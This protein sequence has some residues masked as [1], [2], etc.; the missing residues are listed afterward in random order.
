M[1]GSLKI[2]SVLG[3]TIRLHVLLLVLA[4]MLF[5]GQGPDG[6]LEFGI[7]FAV[8]LLHELGHSVVAQSLGVQVVD[9]TLWPLGGIARMSAMPE[10]SRV[11][12]LVAIAG[13]LVNF[14]LAAIA[15][16]A[17]LVVGVDPEELGSRALSLFLYCNLALGLFNL[18]PAFPSDGGRI[19]RALIALRK[20]WLRATELAVK[21]G[22]FVA[23][24]L[25]LA[26][27]VLVFSS[28]AFFGLGVSLLLV[29]AFLWWTGRQELAAVRL[30]HGISPFAALAELLR[31][32]MEGRA[33][34]SASA[35]EPM[36]TEGLDDG[37]LRELERYR[38]SLKSWR[39]RRD[40]AP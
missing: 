31:R 37:A 17:L 7:L 30:R 12:G 9:I 19:L 4:V 23:F 22:G 13:P 15:F 24:L 36:P 16:S 25:A 35:R 1:F 14:V 27:C 10:S 26:G 5:F 18:I 39:G 8:V 33:A 40:D 6:L 20:D 29:G 2:G 11:E 32:S 28:S 3:I 21:V 38:G 34:E